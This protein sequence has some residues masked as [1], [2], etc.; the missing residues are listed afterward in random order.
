MRKTQLER[1][2]EIL[3]QDGVVSRNQCLSMFP[4]ITRL[5]ARIC[6]L[7]ADGWK[8]RTERRGGDYLYHVVAKPAARQ[9]TLV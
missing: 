5:G 8:F 3:Q 2:T 1:I 4:A 9:L 7:E 6:D